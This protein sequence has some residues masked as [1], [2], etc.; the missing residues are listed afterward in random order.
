VTFPNADIPGSKITL[1][2]SLTSGPWIV[3]DTDGA[4]VILLSKGWD[5]PRLERL[6]RGHRDFWG[7]FDGGNALWEHD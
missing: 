7:V 1:V 6:M 5:E 3:D 2:A 4:D